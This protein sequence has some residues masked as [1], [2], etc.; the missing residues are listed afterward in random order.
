MGHAIT[1]HVCV[2]LVGDEMRTYQSDG[3]LPAIDAAVGGFNE[4]VVLATLFVVIHHPILTF[5]IIS[6]VY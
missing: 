3:S 4:L 6:K 5:V 1:C 2:N